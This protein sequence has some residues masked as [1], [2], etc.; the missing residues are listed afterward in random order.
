MNTRGEAIAY[1]KSLGLCTCERLVSGERVVFVGAGPVLS[2]SGMIAFK[3]GAYIRRVNDLWTVLPM[4]PLFP[5][6]VRLPTS[7][8]EACDDAAALLGYVLRI[9]VTA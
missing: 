3:R 9:P 2:Q 4:Q 5:G 6:S 1:L 8:Q 7:L